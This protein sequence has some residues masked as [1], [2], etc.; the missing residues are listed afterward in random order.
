MARSLDFSLVALYEALDAQRETRGLSWTQVTRE[1]NRQSQRLSAHPISQ[2]TVQGIRTHSV[3]EGDGVLQ[4]LLWLD[5][6]PE[7]FMPG[8]RGSEIGAR[9]PQVPPKQILRFDT[10]KLHAALDARR[11]A[12]RMTWEQ[13]AGELGIGAST[14]T[15]LAAGGRTTFPDVMRMV[16][17]LGRPAAEFTR[18]SDA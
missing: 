5:R 14:L 11:T 8:H 6:T 16:G 10:P 18:A 2:S 15:R 1:I 13:V 17:W 7:S 12:E 4:M 3:V 9:L